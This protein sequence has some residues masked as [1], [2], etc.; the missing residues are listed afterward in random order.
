MT[1]DPFYS[2]KAKPR[3][4]RTPQPGEPVWTL[5][6]APK[7]L[8]CELRDSGVF[9]CEVQLFRD[10]EFFAARRFPNRA[11]ALAHATALRARLEGGGW[12]AGK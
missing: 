2:P 9:G 12:T 11:H 4:P 8:A 3:P 1:D 5:T 6:K 7:R 10:G